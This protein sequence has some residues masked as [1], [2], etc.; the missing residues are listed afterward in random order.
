MKK[1][2]C[3]TILLAFTALPEEIFGAAALAGTTFGPSTFEGIITIKSNIVSG[4]G[5]SVR[6][7][8]AN[9]L[10]ESDSREPQIFHKQAPRSCISDLLG[11]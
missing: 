5:T 1:T 4:I 10:Q 11:V 3:I 6:G 7:T 2:I 8:N 9:D